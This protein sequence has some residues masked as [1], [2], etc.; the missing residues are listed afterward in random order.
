M[1][2]GPDG[3]VLPAL[4]QVVYVDDCVSIFLYH[5]EAQI[6]EEVS[7]FQED[8]EAYDFVAAEVA[9]ALPSAASAAATVTLGDVLIA[10][11]N[12]GWEVLLLSGGSLAILMSG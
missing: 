5:P 8:L 9:A 3:L 4:A 10:F 7:A 12:L 11:A 1:A 6:I 2:G